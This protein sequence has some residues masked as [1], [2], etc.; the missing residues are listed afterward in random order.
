MKKIIFILLLIV[1]S[2]CNPKNSV[3]GKYIAV[4]VK[5][6]LI[7]SVIFDGEVATFGGLYKIMPASNYKVK[8]N[9]IY[10]ETV[11][12]ILVFEI[13]NSNTIKGTTSIFSG[14][15]KK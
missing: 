13:I 6:A 1:L 12:G 15:Y 10:I 7:E 9:K 8:N 3:K 11:E 5:K 14:I 4:D 2:S